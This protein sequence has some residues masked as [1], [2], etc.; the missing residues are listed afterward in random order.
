[1]HSSIHVFSITTEAS[2]LS[3]MKKIYIRNIETKNNVSSDIAE[4]ARDFIK[5][6]I[7]EKYGDQ[8]SIISEE[9]IKIMFKQAELLQ[10]QGAV[11]KTAPS[12]LDVQLMQMK[13]YTEPSAESPAIFH[14]Q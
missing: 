12:M 13:L 11:L 4:T 10:T 7:F 9:D 6:S 2:D 1:M 3:G 14:F 8:Y 5:L